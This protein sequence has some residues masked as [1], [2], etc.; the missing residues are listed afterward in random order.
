MKPG[1]VDTAEQDPRANLER[2]PNFILYD[3]GRNLD[4]ASR[5][6]AIKILCER[7]SEYVLRP[8]IALEIEKHGLDGPSSG[9]GDIGSSNDAAN[10]AIF[11][12]GRE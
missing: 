1:V 4:A 6:L 9:I 11:P 7:G 3:V 2:L 10:N 12:R 8:E 5:L